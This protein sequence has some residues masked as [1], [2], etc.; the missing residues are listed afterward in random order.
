MARIE[1][2]LAHESEE[3]AF[4]IYVMHSDDGCLESF[5]YEYDA[6]TDGSKTAARALASSRFLESVKENPDCRWYNDLTGKSG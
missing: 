3:W 4:A 2:Q 5:R 6:D 1:V